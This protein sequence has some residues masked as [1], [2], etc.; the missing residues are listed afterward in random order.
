MKMKIHSYCGKNLQ[1]TG[2]NV[3]KS[4]KL[5]RIINIMFIFNIIKK[6]VT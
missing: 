4:R 6:E 5:G 3:Q 1:K 2:E